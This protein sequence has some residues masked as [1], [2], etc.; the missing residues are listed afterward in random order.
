VGEV[1]AKF[2]RAE[3]CRRHDL[4]SQ[5][6]LVSLLPGSRR[7][8]LQRIMPPLLDGAALV[9]QR[10]PDVQFV[11]V[12]A[13]SRPLEEAQVILSNSDLPDNL[14][15]SLRIVHRETREAL[16]ASDATAIASGTA[17]LE[18]ALLGTPMVIVYRE[19]PIN[20]HTLGR[21]ITAEHYGLVNLIAGK[22]VATELMQNEFT[23]ERVAQELLALLEQSQNVKFRAQLQEVVEKLG[24]GGASRRAAQLIVTALDNP[25]K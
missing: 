19:S 21:L 8:E 17:T 2:D 5:Q 3:F 25:T 6:P 14:K 13:P 23:A 11:L 20:W 1:M 16:A 24:D 12:V 22:R 10:R 18:A 15:R 7:K 9:K 4:N